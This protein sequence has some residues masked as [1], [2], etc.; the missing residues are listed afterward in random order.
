MRKKPWMTEPW[1]LGYFEGEPDPKNDAGGA[2]G[3][4]GGAPPV[5][6]DTAV[7]AKAAEVKAAEEVRNAEFE[8]LKSENEKLA[9]FKESA[10]QH[11]TYD[12]ETGST[13]VREKEKPPTQEDLDRIQ[14]SGEVTDKAVQIMEMN[15]QAEQKIINRYKAED[16][17]FAVTFQKAR[18]KIEKLHPSQRTELVWERAMSMAKGESVTDYSKYYEEQGRKK[19]FDEISRAGG[20]TLPSGS[21]G[22]GGNVETGKVDVSKVVLSKDQIRAAN[23]MIAHGM[24]KNMDEYKENLVYLGNVEVSQ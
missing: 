23:Q 17:L 9:K 12:E 7:A 18:E 21:G 2:G 19:A 5:L 24:L 4:G 6:E 13:Y 10:S 16:P 1:K 8:R 22:G 3:G 15:R 20:A 14:L 11:V